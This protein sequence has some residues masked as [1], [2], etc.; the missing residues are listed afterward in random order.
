MPLGF[1]MLNFSQLIKGEVQVGLLD[2]MCWDAEAR[3]VVYFKKLDS[4]TFEF[5]C[6]LETYK[7]MMERR[8]GGVQYVG[9][10]TFYSELVRVSQDM[11]DGCL[12]RGIV[13]P[14]LNTLRN[15]LEKFK[16]LDIERSKH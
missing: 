11:L 6:V 15:A 16:M 1:W 13:S 14:G 4:K 7:P 12:E 8:L 10:S 9:V 5:E 3:R 2:F